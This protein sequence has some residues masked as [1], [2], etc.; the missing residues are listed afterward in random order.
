MLQTHLN[1]SALGNRDPKLNTQ[2]NSDSN[3]LLCFNA[4][5]TQDTQPA[6]K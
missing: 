6:G 3:H 2:Y 1:V 5:L 4:V